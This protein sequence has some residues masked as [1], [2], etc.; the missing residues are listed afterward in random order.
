MR[1]IQRWHQNGDHSPF[2]RARHKIDQ[3]HEIEQYKKIIGY[4]VNC[5]VTLNLY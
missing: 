5:E 1:V 3:P 4:A 2:P